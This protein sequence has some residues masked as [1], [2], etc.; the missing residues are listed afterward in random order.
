MTSNR[1]VVWFDP[2]DYPPHKFYGFNRQSPTIEVTYPL[3]RRKCL[4]LYLYPGAVM[5]Y[6]LANYAAVRM[7]NSR[8]ANGAKEVYAYPTQDTQ[9]RQVQL[10]DL[11][12]EAFELPLL[13]KL[14]DSGTN[15]NEAPS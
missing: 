14:L 9:E 8:T 11:G 4:F 7:V 13:L 12:S 5:Q 6:A 3:T 15:A 10:A 2:N 1:P